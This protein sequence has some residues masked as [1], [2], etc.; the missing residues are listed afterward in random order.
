MNEIYRAIDLFCGTGGFSK[1]MENAGLK[2][3]GA[4][5]IEEKYENSFN[6]NHK[7]QV[8]EAIDLVKGV[9]EKIEN[10]EIDIVFGSPPCQGFSDARG[11]RDPK[12]NDQFLRNN[13]PFVFIQIV[14]QIKP[15]I[16]IMENVTGMATFKCNGILLMDELQKK[17]EEI[18]YYMN[19]DIL[20]SANFGVPQV[21]KRVICL[22]I[23]KKYKLRPNLIW[24]DIG[25]QFINEIN[26]RTVEDALGDLGS[27]TEKGVSEY[28]RSNEKGSEYQ[29]LMRYNNYSKKFF[30]HFLLNKQNDDEISLLE[31]IPE[32]KIYRSSRFGEKFIG[33]WD[34]YSDAFKNDE[35][36]LLHFL[37][38]MRTN[39][40][41]KELKKKHQEG[42]IRENK[43]PR[44]KN[45]EFFWK[46]V[47]PKQKNNE[48]RKPIEIIES[49]IRDKWLRK[50]EFESKLTGEKYFAY[51]IN[52]KSG[53]RPMYMRL[54]RNEPSRTIM[55]TSFRARELVHPTENRAITLREGAR[56]QSFPDNFIFPDNTKDTAR[57]IGNAVPPLMAS[58]IGK[59]I[60]I[61]LEAIK[62]NDSRQYLKIIRNQKA[63][64]QNLK[65]NFQ[66]SRNTIR[67]KYKTQSIDEFF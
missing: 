8:F 52:T 28:N 22:A 10:S 29:M 4:Y 41:F 42:Y 49:L 19:Y 66:N 12:T 5:D 31:N 48:N 38:R 25:N 2:L 27:P 17:F 33:V 67:N 26:F 37:S 51:D 53:I 6:N 59:F 16:A 34:L 21:R 64:K 43:F 7:N 39:K 13:L 60:S 3:L 11:N 32:G 63:H 62:N 47:Y 14:N 9:P 57:M 20:N 54:A 50:R 18:G 24:H 44:G 65:N 45:G 36:E 30:N 40:E 15:K 58:E 55:T 1:G 61:L 23:K 56:I 46:D 35:R